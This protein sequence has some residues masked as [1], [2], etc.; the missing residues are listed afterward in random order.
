MDIFTILLFAI[1]LIMLVY[2]ANQLVCGASEL[3][4]NIGVSRLVVGLTV[5]AFGTSSPEMAVSLMAAGYG[6]TG[7]S[8]GNVVGSNISNILLVLGASAAAAPLVITHQVI[9]LEV[10]IMIGISVV[11]VCFSLDGVIGRWEGA[12]FFVGV[13]V[14]TIWSVRRSRREFR[15]HPQ[16]DVSAPARHSHVRQLGEVAIGVALLLLGSRFLVRSAEEIAISLGV[17]ELIVGL[18]IVA[19]G[20]SLPELATS[21]IASLQGEREIAVGNIVGSNIFNILLVLGITAFSMPQGIPVPT[22]VI[23]FDLPVMLTV[24]VVCLPVFMAGHRID[25]WEGFL[26]LGYYLCYVLFLVFTAIDYEGRFLLRQAMVWF[27][28][29]LTAV[30]L[31]VSWWRKKAS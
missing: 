26:F 30:T 17:S 4:T 1:G 21:I 3:A 10:P 19:V 8:L 5:V 13:F 9:R 18:T 14:Y 29:P 27:A 15:S 24:A 22:A 7:I 2:G 20:T 31:A 25:R 16:P 12:F 11:L 23:T 6:Q 28:F